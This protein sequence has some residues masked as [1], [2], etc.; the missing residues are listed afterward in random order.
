VC[1]LV[2]FL[3]N[4]K[5]IQTFFHEALMPLNIMIYYNIVKEREGPGVGEKEMSVK[6]VV[7]LRMQYG[8]YE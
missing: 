6:T 7:I 5:R 8:P 1:E 4:T 2:S 3:V